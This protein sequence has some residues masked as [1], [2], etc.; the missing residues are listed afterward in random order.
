M[1]EIDMKQLEKAI[2]EKNNA[3]DNLHSSISDSVIECER[4]SNIAYNAGNIISGIDED[5]ARITKLDALDI[6]F[7]FTAIALQ[8][9][10]QYVIGTITQRLDDKSAAKKVKR[11]TEEHSNRSH[12][13]YKPSLAE[14]VTNPVPFDSNICSNG[15]LTG[16]GKLGHR[17]KTAGHDPILGLI[18]G[19]A[20]IATSTLT[21]VPDFKSY[22]IITKNINGMRDAFGNNADTVKVLTYTKNKI[23]GNA[24]EKAIVAASLCKEIIHL[25]SDVFSKNSLPFPVLTSVSP[26]F[27]SDMAKYGIDMA[28]TIKVGTQASFA[29]LINSIIAMLHFLFYDKN[30]FEN[31]NL[32]EVKTRKILSYSNIIASASNVIAVAAGCTAGALTENPALITKSLNYA[33]I[34]GYIV[35]IHRLISDFKFIEEVKEEFLKKHWNEIVLEGE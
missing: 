17:A 23:L 35:T 24:E 29:I 30:K 8:C 22:H 25:R 1:S 2:R 18:F 21:T 15:V 33:D 19:T 34:G 10:R 16:G 20:N 28:N 12:R 3:V 13:Y 26:S 27:A 11:D 7:L 5:F 14:V 31:R 6:T 9:T 4:I 32:Y